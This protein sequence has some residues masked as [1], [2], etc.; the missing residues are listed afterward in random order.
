MHAVPSAHKAHNNLI[1]LLL[2]FLTSSPMRRSLDGGQ[3]SFHLLTKGGQHLTNRDIN[4]TQTGICMKS[5][6]RLHMDE[7]T[8][9]RAK[10]VSENEP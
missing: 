10:K 5:H 3:S 1:K 7:S 4:Y 8:G 9:S 2:N 6:V